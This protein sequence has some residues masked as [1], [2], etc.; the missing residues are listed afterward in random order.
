MVLSVL[1][2]AGAVPLSFNDQVYPTSTSVAAVVA[3]PT[4]TSSNIP[5][6]TNPEYVQFLEELVGELSGVFAT[7]VHQNPPPSSPTSLTDMYHQRTNT[8][9]TSNNTSGKHRFS[10]PIVSIAT[11]IIRSLKDCAI[12]SDLPHNNPAIISR[13]RRLLCCCL[14]SSPS[15]ISSS[16]W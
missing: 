6:S 5:S 16:S 4:L 1:F 2:S 13:R 7:W 10:Q 12:K 11:E 15:T 8:C 3:S 9:R 14:R